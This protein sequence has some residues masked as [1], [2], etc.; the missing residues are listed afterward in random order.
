MQPIPRPLD[1]IGPSHAAELLRC[2][3][4]V[5]WDRDSMVERTAPNVKAVLGTIGHRLCE[6][7]ALGVLGQPD[8]SWIARF[9]G[10]WDIETGLAEDKF[11]SLGAPARWPGHNLQKALWRG[12][13]RAACGKRHAVPDF[14]P[15]GPGIGVEVRLSGADGR[16]AGTADIVIRHEGGIEIRDLKSGRT[17]DASGELSEPYKIQLL[18]YAVMYEET[19]GEWPVRLVI[20]PITRDPIDILPDRGEAYEYRRAVLDEMDSF[21][22]AV[23]AGRLETLARPSPEVCRFCRHV[24]RCAAFW[25]A[26]SP[27]WN[28]SPR[29]LKGRV[30][31]LIPGTATI[32]VTGGTIPTGSW[33]IGGVGGMEIAIGESVEVFNFEWR[34]EGRLARSEETE[35]L[36]GVTA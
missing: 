9:D 13:A 7:A 26:A 12:K 4:R 14:E 32:S 10:A 8:N 20:D 1:S 23:A 31:G 24:L 21:A 36:S 19:Y 22:A 3:Y 5:A 11:P 25:R 34:G 6:R 29:A 15:A 16:L 28:A 30:T 33:E 27:T 17:L 18:L 35:W 2:G